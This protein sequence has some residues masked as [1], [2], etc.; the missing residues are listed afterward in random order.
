MHGNDGAKWSVSAPSGRPKHWI[1]R[2]DLG[3]RTAQI[4]QEDQSLRPNAM[5][6]EPIEARAEVCPSAADRIKIDGLSG[7][8]SLDLLHL[9]VEVENMH[10][11][12]PLAFE[13]RSNL[14]FKETQLPSTNR[15]RA[16]DSDRYLSDALPY[17][18]RQ[19]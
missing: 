2:R 10:S 15:T 7:F 11:L 1:V 17:D 19:I 9:R 6:I 4:G 5:L 3:E 18:P 12:R 13:D 14:G 16:I 8:V